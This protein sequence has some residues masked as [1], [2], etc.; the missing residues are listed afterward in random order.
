M[1]W[2]MEGHGPY[3]EGFLR[4]HQARVLQGTIR[5]NPSLIALLRLMVVSLC[6]PGVCTICAARLLQASKD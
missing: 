4:H 1:I 3:M 6:L 2:Q 5:A